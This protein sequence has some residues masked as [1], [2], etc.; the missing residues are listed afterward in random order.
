M[1]KSTII[2]FCLAILNLCCIGYSHFAIE[3][4]KEHA[5]EE[6]VAK[7]RYIDEQAGIIEVQADRIATQEREIKA[8]AEELEAQ[9][10]E[11]SRGYERVITCEVSAYT[12]G[13]GLTPS[14][15]MASGVPVYVG[16]C[17]CNFLPFGTQVRINGNI[18]TVMDRCGVDN[19]ID[20]YMSSYDECISWGRRTLEVEIL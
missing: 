18:Y 14:T 15:L 17:A 12:A 1:N 8:L 6:I 20:L 2:A 16:A 7:D 19:C 4:V 13:D 11:V 3:E 10:Q 9:K 5:R